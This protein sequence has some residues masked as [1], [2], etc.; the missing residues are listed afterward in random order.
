MTEIVTA[1]RPADFLTLVP[2]LVGFQPV[3]SIVLV[4]F[5][6]TRSSAAMRFDLPGTGEAAVLDGI[7][8]HLIGMLCRVEGVDGLVPVVYTSAP[9]AAAPV[10]L[11]DLLARHAAAAGLDVKDAFCVGGDAWARLPGGVRRPLAE[12]GP[13]HPALLDPEAELRLPRLPQEAME[14]FAA[15]VA[16]WRTRPAGPGGTVHGFQPGAG[17]GQGA[18]RRGPSFLQRAAGGLDTGALL[19]GM[20]LEHDEAEET[21][22]CLAA[23]AAFAEVPELAEHLLLHL[24]WGP[25]FGERVRRC[26]L[27]HA[28][29]DPLVAAALTGGEMTR[30]AIPRI[31]AALRAVRVG[32]GHLA[33]PD[34]GPLAACAAWFHWALGRGSLAAAFLDSAPATD[35]PLGLLVEAKLRRGELP[36]WAFRAEPGLS[37]EQQV[38]RIA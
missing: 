19:E 34:R 26:R 27:E 3:E 13:H 23:L 1:S 29:D 30:P 28:G 16:A 11:V 6:G 22:P 17:V 20:L 8:R 24:A 2:R 31:D 33:P 7:A 9:V 14:R 32:L 15:T 10:L 5:T 12:L 38:R 25:R 18:F 35:S 4:V 21:C 37:V 36:E